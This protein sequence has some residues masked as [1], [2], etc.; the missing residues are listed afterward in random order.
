MIRT[1]GEY[2]TRLRD[3]ETMLL[4]TSFSIYFIMDEF[5]RGAKD[6]EP[7]SSFSFYKEQENCDARKF[8]SWWI[9]ADE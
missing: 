9:E 6:L 2:N 1:N 4:Q 8:Y 3:Y 7:A 5:Y